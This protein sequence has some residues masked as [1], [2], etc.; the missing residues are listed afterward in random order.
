[1][2]HLEI[3]RFSPKEITFIGLYLLDDVVI[4]SNFQFIPL[5]LIVVFIVFR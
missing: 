4:I 1:M 5:L 2:T 3:G